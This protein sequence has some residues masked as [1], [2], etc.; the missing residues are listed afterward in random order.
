MDSEKQY[1]KGFNNGFFLAEHV[2]QPGTKTYPQPT[3]SQ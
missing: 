1:I 3:F 2:P